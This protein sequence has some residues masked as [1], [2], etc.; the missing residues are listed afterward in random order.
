[1]SEENY[2]KA[3]AANGNFPRRLMNGARYDSVAITKL[4]F[5][6]YNLYKF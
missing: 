3:A 4:Y 6:L 2:L 1:M 5:N